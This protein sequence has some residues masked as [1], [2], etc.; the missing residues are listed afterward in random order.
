[1]R[2]YRRNKMKKKILDDP[3]L[4]I[5]CFVMIRWHKRKKKRKKKNS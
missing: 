5:Y 2:R 3:K 1:M 4:F